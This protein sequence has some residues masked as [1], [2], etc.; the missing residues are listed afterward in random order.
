MADPQTQRTINSALG[1]IATGVG[2]FGLNKNSKNKKEIK[3]NSDN[4]KKN[5]SNLAQQKIDIEEKKIGVESLIKEKKEFYLGKTN[6]NGTVNSGLIDT[7]VDELKETFFSG[8]NTFETGI[9]TLDNAVN[10]NIDQEKN[11]S[12]KANTDMVNSINVETTRNSEK[13]NTLNQQLTQHSI[14]AEQELDDLQANLTTKITDQTSDDWLNAPKNNGNIV[15]QKA[16]NNSVR[17]T[18]I[19]GS[20]LS[21]KVLSGW[22]WKPKDEEK[23][24]VVT[25]GRQWVHLVYGEQD[26]TKMNMKATIYNQVQK[27]FEVFKVNLLSVDF[28]NNVALLGFNEQDEIDPLF[29]NINDFGFK[30]EDSG[31]HKGETCYM[32]GEFGNH[33][34]NLSITSGI[35]RDNNFTNTGYECVLLDMVSGLTGSFGSALLNKDGNV[36]GMKQNSTYLMNGSIDTSKSYFGDQTL[37]TYPF[38]TNS[39]PWFNIYTKLKDG[40]S[41]GNGMPEGTYLSTLLNVVPE[42]E[43][44]DGI[45]NKR[46]V[47]LDFHDVL[48]G[49]NIL[50]ENNFIDYTNGFTFPNIFPANLSDYFGEDENE[51]HF[52]SKI[53]IT[54]NQDRRERYNSEFRFTIEKDESDDE[55]QFQLTNFVFSKSRGSWL[56]KDGFGIIPSLQ[57]TKITKNTEGAWED[58]LDDQENVITLSGFYIVVNFEENLFSDQDVPAP[59]DDLV[60][61]LISYDNI[62]NHHVFNREENETDDYRGLKKLTGDSENTWMGYA[63]N[64]TTPGY[65]STSRK[66]KEVVEEMYQIPHFTSNNQADLNITYEIESSSKLNTSANWFDKITN[67]KNGE[68]Y[69]FPDD[70]STEDILKDLSPDQFTEGFDAL[71]QISLKMKKR[72]AQ[73]SLIYAFQ[74][75]E[76][77]LDPPLD[78]PDP[79]VFWTANLGEIIPL[80]YVL[81]FPQNAPQPGLQAFFFNSDDEESALETHNVYQSIITR[82][83][84]RLEEWKEVTTPNPATL[85]V[86]RSAIDLSYSK[87]EDNVT[88]QFQT[89]SIT[90]LLFQNGDGKLIFWVSSLF[91]RKLIFSFRNAVNLAWE[92][93]I[94]VTIPN[95][96]TT[97]DSFSRFRVDIPQTPKQF[98]KIKMEFEKEKGKPI[99]LLLAAVKSDY[100]NGVPRKIV[101]EGASETI[102]PEDDWGKEGRLRYP[103]IY[104]SSIHKFSFEIESGNEGFDY[105]IGD[106]IGLSDFP[107]D[108]PYP[109]IA[110]GEN[111]YNEADSVVLGGLLKE[112]IDDGVGLGKIFYEITEATVTK[113]G[114]GFSGNEEFKLTI[115]EENETPFIL[116]FDPLT[117]NDYTLERV[118]DQVKDIVL[119]NAGAGFLTIPLEMPI[120]IPG[121]GGSDSDLKLSITEDN[122]FY[123][124]R[125]LMKLPDLPTGKTIEDFQD[126]NQ[127]AID[128]P[129]EIYFPS[130]STTDPFTQNTNFQRSATSGTFGISSSILNKV[131]MKMKKTSKDGNIIQKSLKFVQDY[132]YI[133][134]WPETIDTLVKNTNMDSDIA[135]YL[136]GQ[137]KFPYQLNE[138]SEEDY[139]LGGCYIGSTFIGNSTI[140]T[141]NSSIINE[142]F[143]LIRVVYQPLDDSDPN[144]VNGQSQVSF[145]IGT[146]NSNCKSLSSIMQ[147]ITKD[148]I[149]T[150]QFHGF[151]LTETSEE[152]ENGETIITLQWES[153]I[154]S[155]TESDIKMSD[156]GIT[157]S[158]SDDVTT[159]EEQPNLKYKKQNSLLNKL[160]KGNKKFRNILSKG[161]IKL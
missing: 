17:L 120:Q 130:F 103:N 57:A 78:R 152:T 32:V 62:N 3:K 105:Q 140:S 125:I 128:T 40:L 112:D 133:Y 87:Y 24:Y 106:G 75:V 100:N 129:G 8:I 1:A 144:Y 13:M 107:D 161:L 137:K 63:S 76:A 146:Y 29:N 46:V 30:L 118:G 68:Q 123:Y 110:M 94:Q 126:N 121:R 119:V 88:L 84:P 12:E 90:N 83:E 155:F 33:I 10:V 28:L 61:P 6:D 14:D 60:T 156:Y 15:Y 49:G 18:Q 149:E 108:W 160:S 95:T 122:T 104:G 64:K 91:E 56:K 141:F 111:L 151:E 20:L 43:S 89:G 77:A 147:F 74:D 115:S 66:N 51:I 53:S 93:K 134:L 131:L 21:D 19:P 127:Q 34:D 99:F 25:T 73:G 26:Q 27:S 153:K 4:I 102:I 65:G 50:E 44:D 148:N 55:P 81:P 54:Y 143:I 36:I 82:L 154:R 45:L 70:Q 9:T 38:G 136:L 96:V 116:E 39:T 48:S 16:M 23:L 114:E 52:R 124:P 97:H 158:S 72:N 71:G 85:T 35:V 11:K 31:I 113:T 145:P 42:N 101:F 132:A 67:K 159:E 69:I 41:I 5:T 157:V 80:Y 135:S 47:K 139:H 86:T 2:L 138:N 92:G 7:K 58:Y 59:Y 109:N 142:D 37:S 22:L 150:L 79:W 98:D 117:D